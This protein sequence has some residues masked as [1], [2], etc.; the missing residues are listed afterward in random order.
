[1]HWV[2]NEAGVLEGRTVVGL[3]CDLTVK[4]GRLSTFRRWV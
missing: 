2:C 1:M 3:A 4:V